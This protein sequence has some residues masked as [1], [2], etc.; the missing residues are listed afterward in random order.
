MKRILFTGLNEL[1]AIAAIA[2]IVHHIELYKH[3]DAIDSLFQTRLHN[4]ISSLGENG[5]YLFFVLSGFLITYLLLSEFKESGDIKI[6][7]F[8][9]R[10]LLRIWPL[11]YFLLIICFFILP[12]MVINN[13]F[14][15]KSYYTKVIS[16]IQ[17]G[18]FPKLI[19][20]L[21]FLP[22]LALIM[23]KPIAGLAQSWSV[24]VEEQFYLFWPL[25]IYFCRKHLLQTFFFILILKPI[26][27]AVL[28]FINGYLH[29][30]F[31]EIA[32]T[33]L[34]YFKIELMALGG[35]GGYLLFIKIMPIG[36]KPMKIH[37]F[38]IVLLIF[39][40]VLFHVNYI[41]LAC[42]FLILILLSTNLSS[43]I[44]KNRIL[45]SL[46]QI[47][48]GLYMYH[49]II[50]F[51]SFSVLYKY[52]L[53]K[54]HPIVAN[55]SIYILVFVFTIIVSRL[56]FRFLELPFLGLKEKFSVIKSGNHN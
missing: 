39:I 9:F 23:F 12:Y 19:T 26:T 31:L 1:R 37:S 24:G 50:M 51:F 55:F 10:R 35:I 44:F 30:S 17:V 21:L 48:Y 49:P 15:E 6:R 36:F 27:L 43:N 25:V 28:I 53:F 18:F 3:R 20:F 52:N 45:S 41:L 5:V 7:K 29:L 13:D 47:S 11:Y 34:I 38:L 40:C 56:S 16:E 22:N 46:G 8:Y 54:T 32:I 2:V 4:I 42:L 33:Y 14:F